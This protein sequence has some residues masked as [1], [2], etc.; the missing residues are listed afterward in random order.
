MLQL[1]LRL[2]IL[3]AYV[4]SLGVMSVGGARRRP[5]RAPVG[6]RRSLRRLCSL[7]VLA[8]PL[9]IAVVLL[10]ERWPKAAARLHR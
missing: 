10:G 1:R 3:V 7:P 4:A 8:L 6:S 5:G 2:V 9:P